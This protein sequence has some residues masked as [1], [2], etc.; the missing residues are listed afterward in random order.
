MGFDQ[1]TVQQEQTAGTLGQFTGNVQDQTA[2]QSI[3]DVMAN[4][5]TAG[6]QSVGGL[7]TPSFDNTNTFGG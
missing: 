3:F 1:N 7:S 6:G 4:E 2:N 5:G